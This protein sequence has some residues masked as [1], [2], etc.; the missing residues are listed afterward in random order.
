MK[1]NRPPAKKR[2]LLKVLPQNYY[3]DGHAEKVNGAFFF[4]LIL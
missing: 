4:G 3:D 1:E 2:Q